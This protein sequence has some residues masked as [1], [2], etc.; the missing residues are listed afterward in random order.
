MLS[1]NMRHTA[2]TS[3]ENLVIRMKQ[4]LLT[5]RTKDTKLKTRLPHY[6]IP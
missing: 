1:E 5:L 6:H 4:W 3:Q 2:L